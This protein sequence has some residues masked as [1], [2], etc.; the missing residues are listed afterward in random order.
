MTQTFFVPGP[1]PGA[2]DIVRKHWRV[3]S[4]LKKQW[5]ATIGYA[6]MAAKIKPMAMAHI[7]F[8]WHEP[9]RQR[10]QRRDPDN[11]IFGEKFVLDAIVACGILPDDSMDEVLSLTHTWKQVKSYQRGGVQVTVS[12]TKDFC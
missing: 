9:V 8:E 11:I 2:N 6:L 7:S 1:L 4:N 3:Y 5:G 10:K 12:D